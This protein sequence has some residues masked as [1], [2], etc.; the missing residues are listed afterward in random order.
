RLVGTHVDIT[1]RKQAEEKLKLSSR[2]FSDTQEGIFIT[3]ANMAIVDINP[4]FC[5]ITGYSREEVIGRNSSFLSSDKQSPEFYQNMWQTTNEHGHW[6]GEVWNCKKNG[7]MYAE[8]L[9]LSV[10]KNDLDKVVNYVG[11]SSD[12]TNSKKQQE[13]LSLMA[14]YDVLTGLP[15]RALFVDR[16]TQAI[17][18]SQRTGLQL[19]VCF[20]DLD[21]FKPVNDN[22]GHE[23]GDRLLIEV[24]KRLSASL[25][26]EDTV[27]RQGGDEFALLLNDIESIAQCE[28]TLLRIHHALAQPY[29]LDG[30]VHKITASSGVTLYPSNN[31]DIDTLLRHADKAMYQAKLAGKHRY[32]LFDPEH[33]QRTIKKHHQLQEIER[34]LANNEFQLYY[35]P[36]VNM[37]SGKVF[38][39]EALI[40]WKHPEKGLIHPLDFLPALEGTE[41]EIKVGN[42]VV[43]Q[44]VLQLDLWCKQ[45]I[46]IEVSVNIAS[47]HLLSETF[48]TDLDTVLVRHPA[49]DS[50]HLQ[51]EILESSALGDLNAIST[52]IETC[53]SAFGVK[54]ALDDFGTGYSSLT[55]LRSL[56]VDT[57]K[58]DQ[59]FV[60]DMLDD[61]SD[62]A[63]IDSVIGLAESFDRQVIAE[64]VETTNHGLMLLIMGC[65][66]AQ[67]YAIAKPMPADD[68]PQWLSNYS[69]KQEWLHFGNKDRT[70][71]E[72]K[73]KLFKL[74]TNHWK[75]H[76]IKNIQSSPEEVEH[77][78]ILTGKHCHCSTWIKHAKQKQ[79]FDAKGLKKF[80][81]A[82]DEF[83]L[84]A[85]ALYT[86]Y[87]DG[88]VSS[89]QKRLPEFQAAFDNMNYA[90]AL[91]D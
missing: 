83:H 64:G 73:V 15:N 78:P 68:I 22:Y 21:D 26:D 19:A 36:K 13:R 7:E 18:H 53:R 87:Y 25:R 10:L 42:W 89:A 84:I 20:L 9:T 91:G 47:L 27:S 30:A 23:V 35:Q 65:E 43:S 80:S 51:L 69:P 28:Q 63:I 31:G 5:K 17:A 72:N 2:V 4:A 40:R 86:Q 79:F 48:C 34:A 33:D 71:K 90:L 70:A 88:D 54:V 29:I 77:W 46:T 55:H 50:Q 45:D 8:L 85:H 57:I 52:T 67:G 66:T 39:A 6:Q 11:V 14:H 38:G 61:P 76:F 24:T 37:A 62:Y 3:D 75:D 16:F 59:S 56:P 60:R 41:L 32:H 49:V 12:I 44:A 81:D 1:E 58:I 82:H 74:T